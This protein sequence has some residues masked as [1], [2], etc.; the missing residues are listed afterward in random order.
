VAAIKVAGAARSVLVR[1]KGL[2]GYKAPS[3]GEKVPGGK[4]LAKRATGASV[5]Q[6]K[7]ATLPLGKSEG[8]EVEGLNHA[9]NAKRPTALK[10]APSAKSVLIRQKGLR[11]RMV[12]TGAAVLGTE[13][14]LRKRSKYHI[15]AAAA[16]RTAHSSLLMGTVDE[17]V[18]FGRKQD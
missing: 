4:G 11:G 9:V 14:R 3:V 7:R 13:A 1:K 10:I 6:A 5:V 16:R 17:S 8:K 2:A 12:G 18:S 15:R